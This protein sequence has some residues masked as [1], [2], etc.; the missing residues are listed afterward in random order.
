[1][2]LMACENKQQKWPFHEKKV[3]IFFFSRLDNIR[4]DVR[5]AEHYP[6]PVRSIRCCGRRIAISPLLF[7]HREI[8]ILV[9]LPR[10]GRSNT[11]LTFSAL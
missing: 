7:F 8:S 3:P 6:I 4:K 11:F 5:D 10:I 2:M 1:M 9:G